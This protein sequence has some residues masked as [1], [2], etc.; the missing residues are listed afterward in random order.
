MKLKH[1]PILKLIFLFAILVIFIILISIFR[2]PNDKSIL[3]NQDKNCITSEE[4]SNCAYLVGFEKKSDGYFYL[5]FDNVWFDQDNNF[6]NDSDKIIILKA[7]PKLLVG[8]DFTNS[9]NDI[10]KFYYFENYRLILKKKDAYYWN[11]EIQ[12]HSSFQHNGLYE[13]LVEDGIV[14]KIFESG[15]FTEPQGSS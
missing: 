8:F 11:P 12:Q 5:S 14:T 6:L 13:I 1:K 4:D 9:F 3:S 15:D 10:G 7:S 2:N